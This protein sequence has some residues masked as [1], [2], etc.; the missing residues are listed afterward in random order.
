MMPMRL[1]F[2]L[3]LLFVPLVRFLLPAPAGAEPAR[4]DCEGG[5]EVGCEVGWEGGWN[6]VST[7]FLLTLR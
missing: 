2:V 6:A 1:A 3:F 7:S 4:G 5:C